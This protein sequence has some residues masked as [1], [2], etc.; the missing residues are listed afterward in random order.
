[1]P[2]LFTTLNSNNLEIKMRTVFLALTIISVFSMSAI[3]AESGSQLETNSK[4][5]IANQEKILNNLDKILN[6]QKKLDQVLE[7]G[8]KLD[9][10]LENQKKLDQILQNL[11]K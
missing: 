7:N 1:M 9:I 10:V 2:I 11:K 6:N 5:I 4:T 8:K 3:A